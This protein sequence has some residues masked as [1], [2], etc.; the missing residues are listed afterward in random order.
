MPST[1]TSILSALRPAQR[2]S[3]LRVPGKYVWCSSVIAA[4]GK[5]HMF[6]AAWDERADASRYTRNE[7]LQNYLQQSEI[8]RSEADTPE[9]PYELKETALRPRGSG[10]W[11]V[12]CCHNP[13]IVRAGEMFVLYFQTCGEPGEPRRIGTATAPGIRGPWTHAEAALPFPLDSVNPAVCIEP[14]GRVRVA[15]RQK[16]MRIAIAEAPSFRGPYEIVNDDICP[17]VRLEDPFL[18]RTG[19]RWHMLVE[20]NEGDL[21]GDVRHGAHL[22]SDDGVAWDVFADEPKAYIHTIEW[23]DGTSTTMDR[24]ERPW[25]LFDDDGRPAYLVTGCLKDGHAFSVVQPLS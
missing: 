9:G 25:L 12:V 4:D 24:R 8:V 15:F 5:W 17:G 11:D 20:D 21:A 16:P 14:D 6:S 22:V 13:C 18:W 3:G 19:G 7:L 10:H 23:T 1:D 2:E